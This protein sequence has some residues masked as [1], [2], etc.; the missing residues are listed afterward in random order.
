[1]TLEQYYEKLEE[2]YE[3]VD[4]D[5]LESIKAYNEYRRNLRKELDEEML[6]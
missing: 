6:K 2:R 3:K 4:W 5:N 1:M